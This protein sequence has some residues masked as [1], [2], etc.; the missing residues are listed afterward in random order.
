MLVKLCCRKVSMTATSLSMCWPFMYL[1]FLAKIC[2]SAM[3]STM[4]SHG[5]ILCTSQMFTCLGLPVGLEIS[6][7]LVPINFTILKLSMYF[8]YQ[9]LLKSLIIIKSPILYCGMSLYV[10]IFC[11]ECASFV[12]TA[13]HIYVCLNL[14]RWVMPSSEPRYLSCGCKKAA[15]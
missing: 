12:L 5:K 6:S 13:A 8:A 7:C 15:R 9:F 3:Q 2:S 1:P 10:S 14:S 4:N 11:L